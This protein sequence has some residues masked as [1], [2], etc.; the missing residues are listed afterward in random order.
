MLHNKP[1]FIYHDKLYD[2]RDRDRINGE[3]MPEWVFFSEERKPLYRNYCRRIFIKALDKAELRHIRIHDL[4]HTYASLLLQ[5]GESMV[6]VRDQLGH[7]SIKVT[8]DIYG[9]LVPGGNKEAVDRLDDIPE[10]PSILHPKRN[11]SA[12]KTKNDLVTFF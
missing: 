1:F 11:L 7:H 9:H 2:K 8:V 12:S 10:S 6:Y 3:N 4:R 5:A